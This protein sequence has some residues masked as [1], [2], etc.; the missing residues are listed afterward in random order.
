MVRWSD[1]ICSLKEFIN[2]PFLLWGIPLICICLVHTPHKGMNHT[3]LMVYLLCDMSL[4]GSDD[5]L[6]CVNKTRN[7]LTPVLTKDVWR[8]TAP[9]LA[10]G[11]RSLI[12]PFKKC[13]LISF[14]QAVAGE[15]VVQSFDPSTS[16]FFLS[17]K[18]NKTITSPSVVFLNEDIYYP[19]GFATRLGTKQY[20]YWFTDYCNCW[21][22]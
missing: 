21:R 5:W 14:S 19:N 3:H 15:F 10:G 8:G 2:L 13:F 1:V 11:W 12:S 17:F 4:Y 9:T 7:I 6:H 20:I 18:A 22:S 16:T